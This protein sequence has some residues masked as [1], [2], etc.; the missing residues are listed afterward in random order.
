MQCLI[1]IGLKTSLSIAS[2]SAITTAATT[3]EEHKF[4]VLQLAHT[5]NMILVVGF[6][7]STYRT[8][9]CVAILMDFLFR[10]HLDMSRKEFINNDTSES[11]SAT[12]FF[13]CIIYYLQYL[14][15]LN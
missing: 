4:A 13:Y 6:D 8:D 10:R 3:L 7:D 5:H 2:L 15:S 9:G 1:S 12:D 14:N 11:P